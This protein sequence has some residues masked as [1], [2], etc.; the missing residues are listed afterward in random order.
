[1]SVIN[2]YIYV[3]SPHFVTIRLN[4]SSFFSGK[5]TLLVSHCQNHIETRNSLEI[6]IEDNSN[7]I[8]LF[9]K[10][11]D[12]YNLIQENQCIYS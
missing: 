1:M 9:L 4:F 8:I 11:T 2:Q 5:T 3:L 6:P 10:L 12:L 7:T